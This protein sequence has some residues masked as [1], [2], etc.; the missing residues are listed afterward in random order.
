[1]HFDTAQTG[2]EVTAG[3]LDVNRTNLMLPVTTTFAATG[4]FN[5]D[6]PMFATTWTAE[7][8]RVPE[9]GSL[10]LIAAALCA[11]AISRRRSRH[12]I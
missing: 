12:Q 8:T 6:L 5:P 2:A 9:P 7:L 1:M 4:G 11:F 10:G 3:A